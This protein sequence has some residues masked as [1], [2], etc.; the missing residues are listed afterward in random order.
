MKAVCAVL[1][2]LLSA[3]VADRS[4]F[5]PALNVRRS[6]SVPRPSEQLRMSASDSEGSNALLERAGKVLGPAL[7]AGALGGLMATQPAEAAPERLVPCAESK[8]FAAKMKA[9]EKGLEARLKKYTPESQGAALLNGRLEETKTRA[10]R[11]KAS[12]LLCGKDG[13]PHLIVDVRGQHAGEFAAPG[14][15]FLYIAGWIGW[16][17]RS[18]LNG[19]QLASSN[20]ESKEI[21]LDLPFALQVMTRS[22]TWPFQAFDEAFGKGETPVPSTN[23]D[24]APNYI[25]FL[26]V[27]S[28]ALTI[29]MSLTAAMLILLNKAYP[30]LLFFPDLS[31]DLFSPFSGK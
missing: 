5:V 8:K 19:V 25:R 15:L 31:T 11:Y 9:Q 16:A 20:P 22:A 14:L 17:G 6:T 2:C 28:V 23:F 12:N 21:V 27:S 29:W 10:E 3:A 13:L 1:A 4:A 24:N 7:A 30:G 26:G 18:Y